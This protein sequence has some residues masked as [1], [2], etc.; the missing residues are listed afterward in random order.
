VR[1]V[2]FTARTSLELPD[3]G[4]SVEAHQALNE[5]F[6][7]IAA[8][9]DVSVAGAT[10]AT[11]KASGGGGSSAGSELVLSVPGTLGIR[12]DAA[13]RVSLPNAA[14]P[15]ALVALLKRAPQ[16]AGVTVQ[17]QVAGA[18][19]ATLT[20]PDG[21]VSATASSGLGGI[22]ADAL[23]TVNLT[24]VGTTFPGADLTVLIRF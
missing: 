10:S 21:A 7:T 6:R 8:R 24:S 13:P 19:W 20:I 18:N 17:M 12:T 1:H 5:R 16:G 15:A 3:V 11:A 2:N 14:T 23:V 22:A 4:L 9:L